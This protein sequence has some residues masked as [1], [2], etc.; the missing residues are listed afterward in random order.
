MNDPAYRNLLAA[1]IG[2]F[3]AQEATP[4]IGDI[5]ALAEQLAPILG[6][7][8]P[9]GPLV[10]EAREN[11]SHR[12]GEGVSLV[13]QDAD[14]DADWI[15][16]RDIPWAYSDN[17]ERYLR[18]DGL[19][20]KVVETLMQVSLKV[21]SHLQ[22]P[23]K[24]GKWD[25]RGLVIGH[26]QSG[27]TA[28]YLGL[29]ARAADAG[30]RFIVIVAGIHN[31][32][33][34]QTQERVD[35]GFVGRVSSAVARE[36]LK[37]LG[38]TS[39]IG[40][41]TYPG[42]PRPVTLTTTDSDFR[43]AI[44][45]TTGSALKDWSKP[46]VIVIKK[47]VSTLKALN[48]WLKDFNRDV[49]Q[50]QIADVPMLFVDDEADNASVNTNKPELSPTRTNRLIRE[51][52]SLFHKS[53]YVG[54]TA[55]PFANIF[56]NPDAYDKDTLQDLFPR[57]FI[58]CLDAPT[59]Y[60]GSD[61][62]FLDEQ[63]SKLHLRTIRDCEDV[64]P[65]KHTRDHGIDELPASLR[66][67]I[68]VF[69]LVRSI[70]NLR[71]QLGKHTSMLINVSRFT[72]VQKEV[73]RLVETYRTT[74]AEAIEANAA[75]P[76]AVALRNSHLR[77]LRTTWEEE[78]AEGKESWPE[79]Q[80]A[81]HGAASSIRT[82]VVNS[83]SDEGLNYAEFAERG[84]AMSVIALGGLS[85][86]RG[87]TLE[88]LAVSYM[89]RNTRMYDTLLQMGRW[90]GYRPGYEDLCRVWLSDESIGWYSHIAEST[91]E[92]RDSIKEM[93]RE[94]RSPETFG[95]M[96]QSHPDALLVTAANKMR[97]AQEIPLSVSY[98][99]K[100]METYVVPDADAATRH[101]IELYTA[102][103]NTLNSEH[104]DKKVTSPDV[105]KPYCKVWRSVP[106]DI[107][108]NFLA[109]FTA[110]PDRK[111][112]VASAIGYLQKTAT[113]FATCD[114]AFM[115]LKGSTATPLVLDGFRMEVQRRTAGFDKDGK[116]IR[117]PVA[118]SGYYVTSKQRVAGRGDESVGLT[119]EEVGRAHRIAA[120]DEKPV[121]DR[122][123]RHVDVRGRPLLMLHLLDITDPLDEKKVLL[124]RAPAI[125]ISFP[126][127][128]KY[129]TVE[130]V[131]NKVMLDQLRA[132]LEDGPD[133]GDDFD[134]EDMQS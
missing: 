7:A 66:Q 87:L 26:V 109:S 68:R 78:F 125:G 11:I 28:N 122:H 45:N 69:F 126:H 43:K 119:P 41:G 89:Y 50:T 53:S 123:F 105:S 32:L 5:Q 58:H 96:V 120:E 100:L 30:Y 17:Y 106:T 107:L 10:E 101:N 24:E 48:G 81:L 114:V 99:G 127:T 103:W 2:R 93:N 121:S 25:R 37:Q 27:K 40:V 4:S 71:G 15:R 12:L 98:D 95:L 130:Y 57:H 33:R 134:R 47:N 91:D 86:S 59:N 22:D 63:R 39:D 31:N 9:I 131:V 132:D 116:Q 70:R 133:E 38:R 6:Y 77:D 82:V 104:A 64:I 62:I 94:G 16:K 60:F 97:N 83:K 118:A 115:S 19:P 80:A 21:A 117:K 84:E 113:D 34:M 13:L 72:D 42:H 92:L 85:L 14:H 74:L 76:E 1:L 79:I 3:A 56:I 102:L 108:S 67:A 52:L 124:L 129:R 49:G 73:R 90:F 35:A 65:L 54:Y 44:A 128:G 36:R 75:L 8:G 61:R 55:T 111:P 18:E 88:G 112:A 51:T 23:L 29:V 46:V 110:H 20:G